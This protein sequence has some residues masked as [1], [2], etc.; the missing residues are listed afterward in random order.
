[1]LNC[2]SVNHKNAGSGIRNL[3]SFDKEKRSYIQEQLNCRGIS[4]SVIL[5]TC[6]RSEIYYIGNGEQ[7]SETVLKTMCGE[8][9][10]VGEYLRFKYGEKA[11][12]HLFRVCCGIDSM[13][14]GEDEILGQTRDAYYE[15]LQNGFTGYEI[16]TVFQSAI[17]CA[18]RI[19]TETELSRS[20]VSAATLAAS[21]ASSFRIM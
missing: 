3:F 15:A 17:T 10:D 1:M 8:Y 13:I 12:K 9:K 5:C 2:L 21:E 11:V 18:K 7:D 4:E 20:S 19:K 16:N 6:N 14:L